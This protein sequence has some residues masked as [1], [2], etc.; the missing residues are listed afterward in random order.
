MKL[1]GKRE[2]WMGTEARKEPVAFARGVRTLKENA[3]TRGIVKA[4]T[5]PIAMQTANK[6]QTSTLLVRQVPYMP[7]SSLTHCFHFVLRTSVFF[8]RFPALVM[9]RISDSPHSGPRAGTVT[10]STGPVDTGFSSR[11]GEG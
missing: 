10:I 5:I 4:R 2:N 11:F 8:S 9:S 3:G 7:L 6:D 1:A